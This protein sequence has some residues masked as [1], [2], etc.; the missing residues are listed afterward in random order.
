MQM[1]VSLHQLFLKM[2]MLMQFYK[3]NPVFLH[4]LQDASVS[5]TLGELNGEQEA[6][7]RGETA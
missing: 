5:D 3:I 7:R 6:A 2:H 4:E 1:V